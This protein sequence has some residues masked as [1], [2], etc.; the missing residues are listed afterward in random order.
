M[1]ITKDNWPE[2][3]G[4]VPAWT[5][6]DEPVYEHFFNVLPLITHRG[7][8]FQTDEPYDHRERPDGR[9]S[10]RY[11]T[12]TTYDGRFWFL[13]VQFAGEYPEREGRKCI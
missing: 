1:K 4:R 10:P 5:E 12:F 2:S 3:W 6:I 8:Y 13:G 9:F 7:G 11:L